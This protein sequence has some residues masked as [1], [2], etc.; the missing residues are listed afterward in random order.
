[1]TDERRRE[2]EL[3]SRAAFDQSVASLDAATRS[4]LA[5]ARAQALEELRHRRMSWSSNWVPVGAAAAAALVAVLLWQGNEGGQQASEPA[6]AAL[7]DLDIVA[8]GED[9][10]MFEEDEGFYAWAADE[11]SDGMG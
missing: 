5:R 1:M 3:K 2:L 8:G 4:R 10:D 11:M 7:E 6:L 9:L